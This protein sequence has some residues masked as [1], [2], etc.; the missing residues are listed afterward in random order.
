MREGK[1][2]LHDDFAV[3]GSAVRDKHHHPGFLL[4]HIFLHFSGEGHDGQTVQ[5]SGPCG[6]SAEVG[7]F[8]EAIGAFDHQQMNP[9]T[10]FGMTT[11][12][13]VDALHVIERHREAQGQRSRSGH[14]RMRR[15][16]GAMGVHA[17]AAIDEDADMKIGNVDRLAD[18]KRPCV[19]DTAGNLPEVAFV[20][21]ARSVSV[22]P[23]EGMGV[24]NPDRL[25]ELA[26]KRLS[27]AFLPGGKAAME[28][29]IVPDDFVIE[30]R[31]HG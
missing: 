21:V 24:M 10:F 7:R 3:T 13:D 19:V 17:S 4:F 30:I 20:K 25:P 27:N 8:H 2:L 12:R 15:T 14:D 11:Y 1:S 31:L 6:K 23:V 29:P 5:V 9:S 16:L 26:R 22:I 28:T 18:R